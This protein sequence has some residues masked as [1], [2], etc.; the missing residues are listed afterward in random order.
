MVV[1]FGILMGMV[2]LVMVAM[3]TSAVLTAVAQQAVVV[4]DIMGVVAEYVIKELVV[5]PIITVL[6]APY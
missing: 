6:K 4:V 1:R 2:L 3:E 5:G